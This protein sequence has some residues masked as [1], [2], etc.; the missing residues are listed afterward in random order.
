MPII[1]R[2]FEL[3]KEMKLGKASLFPKELSS[4]ARGYGRMISEKILYFRLAIADFFNPGSIR[5]PSVDLFWHVLPVPLPTHSK[6]CDHPYLLLDVEAD[7]EE[8]ETQVVD[9]MIAASGKLSLLDRMLPRLQVKQA[10][11]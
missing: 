4:L 3:G 6:A 1:G 7:V 11:G 10:R 8:T 9:R 2:L 5:A